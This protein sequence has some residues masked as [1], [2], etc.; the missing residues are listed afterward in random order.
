MAQDQ[1]KN[2]GYLHI[3]TSPSDA[4]IR[5]D[6]ELRRAQKRVPEEIKTKQKADIIKPIG[7]PVPLIRNADVGHD[8]I[9]VRSSRSFAVGDT[10]RI[11]QIQDG[12]LPKKVSDHEIVRIGV[13]D[14]IPALFI[15]PSLID[16]FEVTTGEVGGLG[17]AKIFK[18]DPPKSPRIFSIPV[19][20]PAYL[21]EDV[22]SGAS[23]IQV[24]VSIASRNDFP[25]GSAI[26]SRR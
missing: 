15:R 5:I 8:R 20:A 6:R 21:A 14:S 2:F 12:N 3:E 24:Y 18:I 1:S 10:V 19:V 22:E 23:Q 4:V 25:V 17:N 11:E 9:L 26:R 7:D 13:V 16:S